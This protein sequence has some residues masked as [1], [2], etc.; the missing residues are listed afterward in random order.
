MPIKNPTQDQFVFAQKVAL[1]QRVADYV[2]AGSL[3][4]LQGQTRL[5]KLQATID[6]MSER[7]VFNRSKSTRIRAKKNGDVEGVLLVWA[8]SATGICHWFLLMT[9]YPDQSGLT[10]DRRDFFRDVREH[11]IELTG[12]EL[13][14]VTR[15]DATPTKQQLER[16][17]ARGLP[18]KPPRKGIKKP[19]WT[20]RMS[21]ATE[22]AIRNEII[23]SIRSRDDSKL[24]QIIHSIYRVPGF[25]PIRKQVG[26]MAALIAAEWK[27][28]RSQS[29]Q[30][31]DLNKRLGFIRRRSNTGSSLG[32]LVRH[33]NELQ[34]FK[35]QIPNN[36]QG[37]TL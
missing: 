20:W 31:P 28:S 19:S 4:A 14:R 1:M 35:F 25:S 23:A 5:E 11:P 16:A 33:V 15:A 10:R 6:R 37:R 27:R 29:E 32:E 2:R 34:N 12:Y 3:L 18:P 21:A 17:Q 13:V 30:M 22:G 36:H 7:Y 24:R 9:G 8:D 26:K